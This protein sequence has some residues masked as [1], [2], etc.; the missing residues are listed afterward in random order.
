MTYVLTLKQSKIRAQLRGYE[1]KEKDGRLYY[2]KN[3]EEVGSTLID[4]MAAEPVVS[5]H[6]SNVIMDEDEDDQ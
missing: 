4:S 5:Y 2:Y 1:T 6:A 3:G